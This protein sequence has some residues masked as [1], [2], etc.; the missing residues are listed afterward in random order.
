MALVS[1]CWYAS[2]FTNTSGMGYYDLK[3]IIGIL[4]HRIFMN[5]LGPEFQMSDRFSWLGEYCS[6]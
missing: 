6:W 3:L 5:H 4:P 2:L 1:N